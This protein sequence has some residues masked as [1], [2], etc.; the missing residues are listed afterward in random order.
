MKLQKN[1]DLHFKKIM[2]LCA[3]EK[4]MKFLLII[5]VIYLVFKI[6]GRVLAPML[7]RKMMEKAAKNFEN[8]FNNPYYKEHPETKE[9]ET[10]IEKK[11]EDTPKK[12]SN[13][14]GD[15]VDYEEVD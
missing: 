1:R 14:S 2:Y 12:P 4:F 11:P 15:Y 9:G 13:D 10:Y 5:L 3:K 6:L 8:Q 7:A